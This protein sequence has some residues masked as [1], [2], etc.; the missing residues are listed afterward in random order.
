MERQCGDIDHRLKQKA[1]IN[2]VNR[3]TI[4]KNTENLRGSIPSK[5]FRKMGPVVED[6]SEIKHEWNVRQKVLE[7]FGLD[8]RRQIYSKEKTVN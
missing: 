6:L 1:N 4:L 7:S 8:K 5:E 3:G 2:V